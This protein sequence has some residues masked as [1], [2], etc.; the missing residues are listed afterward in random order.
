MVCRSASC[1]G[2]VVSSLSANCASS[3]LGILAAT[4]AADCAASPL[5]VLL[6]LSVILADLVLD[7]AG[8]TPLWRKHTPRPGTVHRYIKNA[9]PISRVKSAGAEYS[10]R[11]ASMVSRGNSA[12]LAVRV[13][14]GSSRTAVTAASHGWSTAGSSWSKSAASS[15]ATNRRSSTNRVRTRPSALAS[16]VP[17]KCM[18]ADRT[19]RTCAFDVD[20]ASFPPFFFGPCPE[21][22]PLVD[23]PRRAR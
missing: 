1:R 14:R 17:I 19:A 20:A 12:T 8:Y 13:T 4:T 6:S 3:R 10:R 22:G 18:Y 15:G 2:S 23:A 9:C 5:L 21:V 11:R 7:D 16:T